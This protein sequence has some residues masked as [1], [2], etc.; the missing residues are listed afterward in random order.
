MD[1]IL[2][3][4]HKAF[5]VLD[6]IGPR[7]EVPIDSIASYLSTWV[8]ID[9]NFTFGDLWL[10]IEKDSAFYSQVFKTIMG[11]F[12]IEPFLKEA[13]LTPSEDNHSEDGVMLGI[14]I[15][16]KV[17]AR[18][19]KGGSKYLDTH[20]ALHGYGKATDGRDET[21]SISMTP[22]CDLLKYPL[23]IAQPGTFMHKDKKQNVLMLWEGTVKLTL[24]DLLYTIFDEITF[25]GSPA[26]RT[27]TLAELDQRVSWAK[28]AVKEMFPD[29]QP[30]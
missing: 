2:L 17:Q 21:Y 5:L 19:Y 12:P 8:D 24:F 18:E 13:Q 25:Y 26:Q 1:S 3:K 11:N 14:E 6:E 9:E 29:E 28:D 22:I 27:G 4:N 30:E 23:R 7:Q 15:T 20:Y 10:L 16:T